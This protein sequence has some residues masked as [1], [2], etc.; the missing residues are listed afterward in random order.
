M[1]V[2][3][4][5]HWFDQVVCISLG[6][7][8]GP[9]RNTVKSLAPCSRGVT[10][11]RAHVFALAVDVIGPMAACCPRPPDRNGGDPARAG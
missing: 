1:L 10:T 7:W 11:H 5:V 4:L 2:A 9:T 3:S 6:S 8:L